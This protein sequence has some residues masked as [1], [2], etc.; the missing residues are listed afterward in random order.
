MDLTSKRS[1]QIR[2]LIGRLYTLRRL[3]SKNLT[4]DGPGWN[5]KTFNVNSDQTFE[6][7][8]QD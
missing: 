8:S 2:E 3:L 7:G 5:K 6:E 1:N 4:L